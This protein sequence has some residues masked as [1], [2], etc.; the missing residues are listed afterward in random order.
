[1]KTEIEK[2]PL[3]T[4]TL[5]TYP[6]NLQGNTPTTEWTYQNIF[7]HSK[8]G[9]ILHDLSGQILEL[10]RKATELFGYTPTEVAALSLAQL[11]P[12]S[13]LAQCKAALSTVMST[14]EVS[15][16]TNFLRKDGS[17]F[18]AEVS[19]SLFEING[20]QI[21]QGIV[22]DI[23]ERK[24]TETALQQ[25]IE[26]ERLIHTISLRIR[27]SLDLQACLQTT[28]DE[29]R[30]F[31]QADRALI[32]CFDADWSG[33]VPVESV[34]VGWVSVFDKTIQDPCFGES[35]AELFR[36]GHVRVVPDIYQATYRQCHVD[37]LTQFQIRAN[38]IV[39]IL[40]GANLWGLLIVHQCQAP[41]HW[42]ALE[43]DLLQKLS[44]QVAIAVQ[45]AELYAQTQAELAER[46]RIAQALEQARDEALA[47]ARAKSEF[48]AVMSHEIRTPMNGVIGMTGLLLDT[49]LTPQQHNYV[50]TVR[51]CGDNLLALINSILDFSK[52]ESGKLA[53]E[54]S[55]FQVRSCLEEALD[56]LSARAAEKSLQLNYTLAPQTPNQVIGD[57]TRLRQILVNL[58][59]NAVKFTDQGTVSVE[60]S[61][62]I[63]P[64]STP[65]PALESDAVPGKNY[66]L[67]FAVRDTGI[68]IPADKFE[69]LFQPFSQVDSSISRQYGGTGLGLVISQ[70]LCEMMGGRMWVESQVGQGS[71]FY[72]TLQ[73]QVAQQALA[74]ADKRILVVEADAPQREQILETLQH[75]Q[76]TVYAAQSSYEALGMMAHEAPFDGM[77]V[78]RH[79]PGMDGESLVQALR[80]RGEKIPVLMLSE[81]PVPSALAT[82]LTSPVQAD[83][84]Y[85][86]L[87]A[88]FSQPAAEPTRLDASIAQRLPLKILVAEDNLVNQQLVQQWLQKMGYRPELV[89]NGYEVI[90]ALARQSYDLVLMDVQM[91]EMDGLK[92]TQQIHQQWSAIER[93]KIIAM[94]ANALQGDRERCLEMGM[95]AYIS[96][97]I[98][99]HELVTAIEQC[100]GQA[101]TS[102]MAESPSFQAHSE[103]GWIDRELLE[104]TAQALGGL[105]QTWLN[106][107]TALYQQQSPTLLK[108]LVDA[109][110]RQ[111]FEGLT[112]AAHTLKSSSAALGM[113]QVSQWC[114]Q[115]EQYGRVKQ[116]APVGKLLSQLE[117]GLG[118]SLKALRDLAQSLPSE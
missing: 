73:V 110:Q 29:V 84:L 98:R 20:Q 18:P 93:P 81:Q 113:V 45:Q 15:F 103:P 2:T 83:S 78:N 42:Q 82:W 91:P 24:Q 102:P 53:L 1:M 101:Q 25:Q 17:E 86:A 48:L 75:W 105:T 55:P 26:K 12:Q 63:E 23:T 6:P 90:E 88:C 38:L 68:G 85:A 34:G 71:C 100:G 41:R 106:P 10:N 114:Q 64:G 14:G 76:L 44:T 107:F 54:E 5:K 92:A 67:Q 35:Y 109:H 3:P 58:I 116:S 39:P 59:G 65:E 32:Y 117:N 115:L 87:Q 69:R 80:S 19:A 62:H 21:V 28:V 33:H 52:I 22:R 43:I 99:I 13:A 94:T 57:V 36:R 72:F 61:G 79:M 7:D 95:D 70:R 56:L 31:L 50:T 16:E 8:D 49:E 74:L 104:A 96:K 118:Q 112:Y 66:V 40:Q 108:Q 60:V 111:D 27:E 30:A 46:Q 51:N 37:F 77:I 4:A 89:G 9:I 97:P 11:H 47:A